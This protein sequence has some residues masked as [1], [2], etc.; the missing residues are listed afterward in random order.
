MSLDD[1]PSPRLDGGWSSPGLT[2]PYNEA[3][4]LAR[5]S[6][7]GKRRADINGGREITWA[8]AKAASA[9]VNGYPSYQSQNQGFFSRHMRR[10]SEALPYFAHGG[11]EDRFADKEKLGRGRSGWKGMAWKDIPGRVGLLLSR[12]RKYAALLV[13]SLIAVSMWFSKRKAV[14]RCGCSRA[15]IHT[16]LSRTGTDGR[17]S[18][19]AARN[20]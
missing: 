6:S 15:D 9:R 20:L 7:P 13:M 12:R 17:L 16:Q 10:V 8:S 18:L 2:T 1:S 19:A 14:E 4:G 5:G 3:N 11:Q